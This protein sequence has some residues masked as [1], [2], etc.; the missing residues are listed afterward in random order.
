[1]KLEYDKEKL[2]KLCA[3]NRISYLGVF[4]SQ[5]RNEADINSDIDLLVEFFE[6]PSLLKHVGIEYE[7][8]ENL[9][10]N[11]KVDLITKR[12]LNKYIAPYV[13][14]DLITLY[15]SK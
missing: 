10:G 9:F 13:A 11:R 5:A 4:G 14:K 7:F 6:T 12:S 1:M 2:N 3:K 8:S 15:E